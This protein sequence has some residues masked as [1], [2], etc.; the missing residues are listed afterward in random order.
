MSAPVTLA[1]AVGDFLTAFRGRHGLTLDQIA[2]TARDYG[3]KWSASS[4]RNIESGKAV[5]SLQNLLALA[6]A[7]N[8]LTGERLTLSDLLG[9]APAIEGPTFRNLPVRRHWIDS[10]LSGGA[11]TLKASGDIFGGAGLAEHALEALPQMFNEL[12]KSIPRGLIM[13]DLRQLHEDERN[14]TLAEQRAAQKLG[15]STF[16]LRLHALALWRKDLDDEALERA[17]ARSAQT[18]KPVSPQAKGAATRDL[19]KELERSISEMEG[20]EN[21]SP[22]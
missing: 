16:T 8:E 13:E 7:L 20:G 6:L 1:A 17:Y 12:T 19:L 3:A 22:A 15:V 10:V 5:T 2:R 9:D 4:V 14:P 11:V 21:G 18:G